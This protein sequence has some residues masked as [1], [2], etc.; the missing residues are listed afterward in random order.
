M[1]TSW[2]DIQTDMVREEISACFF[3][4]QSFLTNK[5]LN[6]ERNCNVLVF[7]NIFI[8]VGSCMWLHAVCMWMLS[9]PPLGEVM[10]DAILLL[11]CTAVKLEVTCQKYHRS[12]T[13]SKSKSRLGLVRRFSS[14]PVSKNI[15][16]QVGSN[17][18]EVWPGN[19]HED[20][21]ILT[22]HW[23]C[24]Y[25]SLYKITWQE[26]RLNEIDLIL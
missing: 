5:C 15:I 24:Q 22:N 20:Y 23:Q 21:M 8:S 11:V 18:C 9:L 12:T 19:K 4:C 26:S 7:H 6:I 16:R 2:E 1:I 25:H 14:A 10:D 13:Q 17:G 3:R